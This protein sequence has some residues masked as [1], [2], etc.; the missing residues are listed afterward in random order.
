MCSYILHITPFSHIYADVDIN[1]WNG[2]ESAAPCLVGYS[3]TAFD[4]LHVCGPILL[5]IRNKVVPYGRVGK[6]YVPNKEACSR[7]EHNQ[8][9]TAYK[10]M[11]QV[12]YIQDVTNAICLEVWKRTVTES[13]LHA[14][15]AKY[16]MCSAVTF[17]TKTLISRERTSQEWKP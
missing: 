16:Y 7:L 17:D 2:R 14:V 12:Q 10:A 3:I 5:R 9:G 11:I 4:K 8:S 13:T 6:S 1:M 15:K